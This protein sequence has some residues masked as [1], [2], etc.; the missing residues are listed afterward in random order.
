MRSRPR[1]ANV[2]APIGEQPLPP[3]TDRF[4]GCWHGF[5]GTYANCSWQITRPAHPS[6]VHLDFFYG[7]VFVPPSFRSRPP[8]FFYRLRSSDWAN[9]RVNNF[10]FYTGFE[11][12][13][14]NENR[15]RMFF[16]LRK[17]MKIEKRREKRVLREIRGRGERKKEK[18]TTSRAWQRLG[19]RIK[20]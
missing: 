5:V 7:E 16:F 2:F 15:L 17:Y 12:E 6:L 10:K 3:W 8:Q 13:E 18:R 4:F 20:I 1:Y 19:S 14:R 9:P 11:T